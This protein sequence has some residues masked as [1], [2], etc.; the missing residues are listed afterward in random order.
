M[1]V[2]SLARALNARRSGSCWMALCPAHKDR[3]PSLSIAEKDGRVLVHC[4]A[5]CDQRTVID[6]LKNRGIWE[7]E[8]L[9]KE[10]SRI[11]AT[12]PYTDEHGDRLYEV[13]RFDPK[14]FRPR[15]WDKYG[16]E[17]WRKHPQQVLYHLPEVREAPI[18]FV[19]EGEKDVETLRS[20]GFV[21]TTNAGGA[22][23][24]WLPQYTEAL[25]GREVILIPDNDPPGWQR[26]SVI[27]RA[28]L[29]TVPR[30]RIFDLPDEIKDVTDW[31]NA[32]HSEA[33]LISVLE[34][35]RAV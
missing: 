19:V 1:T 28:L 20:H 18:I 17:I 4:H 21:G 14:D 25:R 6:H 33:E 23:A 22:K 10:A 12:Y 16:I 31:F 26:A 8:A 30:I 35:V 15:Y 32:G 11:V 27:A 7:S 9:P 29:G 5:G 13:V 2:D 3:N 34:G 24:P